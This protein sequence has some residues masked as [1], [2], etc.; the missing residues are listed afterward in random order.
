[1]AANGVLRFP[2]QTVCTHPPLTLYQRNRR[3]V[4]VLK[5]RKLDDNESIS[6]S[7]PTK[8]ESK[9]DTRPEDDV[10]KG[11]GMVLLNIY[12]AFGYVMIALGSLLSIGIVLN[13]CGYGYQVTSEGL[14]IDTLTQL[15]EENQF[16]TEVA[17]SMKEYQQ[18]ERDLLEKSNP[19]P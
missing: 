9:T 4:F 10:K 5:D 12:F 11:V 7:A 13:I 3:F 1:M 16:R 15:R 19:S 8:K 2:A 18:Q 6:E 17:K 14:R